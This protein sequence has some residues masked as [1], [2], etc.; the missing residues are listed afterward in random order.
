MTKPTSATA[1]STAA[2]HGPA[3]AQ[4][5]SSSTT[6]TT[7]ATL[8]AGD[9]V[10]VGHPGGP[11]VLLDGGSSRLVSPTTRP[12]SSPPGSSG[13]GAQARCRPA[14]SVP[15]G[16]LRPRTARRAARR[17]A[18]REHR[19]GEVAAARAA[20]PAVGGEPLAGQQGP[21][22]R[23]GGEDEQPRRRVDAVGHPGR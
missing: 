22:G 18:V 1:Q 15:G 7:I 20:E 6:P 9:R 13:S 5:A 11:E 14:R 3:R 16:A 19:R 10:Q 23:V 2:S 17:T 4:R 12:G 8:R 21:P